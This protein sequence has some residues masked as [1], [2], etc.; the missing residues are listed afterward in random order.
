MEMNEVLNRLPK[1]LL[2][3]IIDQPYNEYTAQDHAVWRY[4]MRRN[5][6]YLSKVAHESYIDGLNSTGIHVDQIPSLYG[7]NRILENIGWASAAVDGF[8]PPAAF[9]EFQKYNVL[10]IAADIRPINQ[11]NY[12]P[13]PDIIHEAAGHA[14]I[15][16][17]Q[18][19]ASYLREFGKIGHRA[20]SS[21]LNYKIYE[22]IRHLS[23][24]K[25]DPYTTLLDI[26]AAEETLKAL[27]G[28]NVQLTEMSRIRNLHWWTVEYGL[29]GS[30]E[31]PKIYGAGLLS[32]IGESFHCLQNQVKKIPYSVA[33]ADYRFDITNMQPQL[34]VSPD[35]ATLNTVLNE[36]TS[37]MALHRGG[38]YGLQLAIESENIATVEYS[39]GIQV[40][41]IFVDFIEFEGNCAYIKTSGP[42]TLN[43]NETMLPTH[44]KTYHQS[45]FSSPVG[46][47]INNNIPVEELTDND[48]LKIGIEQ[49]KRALL[50]YESG[51]EVK[52][53]VKSILR[54]NNKI[55]LIAFE[56]CLVTFQ[57]RVLFQPDWGTYDMAVGA[58]IQSAFSGPVDPDAFGLEFPAPKEKTHKIQH[59]KLAKGLHRLYQELRVIRDTNTGYSKLEQLTKETISSYPNDWLLPLELYELSRKT[60]PELAQSLELHLN[61]LKNNSTETS[62]LIDKGMILFK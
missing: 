38:I 50:Q 46:K 26:E 29:I 58:N 53:F 41:G 36:F 44:D 34:F 49:G 37:T 7:M 42:T 13:A 55:I 47:L 30:L 8:I 25:A 11:I 43:Y 51:I 21:A 31:Q 32:S 10:V 18:E 57:D 45:G 62:E 60:N 12:T 22:A 35:F 15:I 54:K 23:I 40:S 14:P 3:L 5:I 1:H 20:F 16:A 9:M 59:S 61:K 28:Q 4:I 56:D 39:S 48:L 52:G 24:L 27:E 2:N 19:Y 6:E 33:A 17:N